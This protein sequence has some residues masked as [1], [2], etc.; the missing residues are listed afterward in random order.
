MEVS[1]GPLIQVGSSLPLCFY[2]FHQFHD[3]SW[4]ISSPLF[5]LQP[6]RSRGRELGWYPL[7]ELWQWLLFSCSVVSDSA[8]PRT[9]ACQTS[10]SFPISWNLLRLMSVDLVVQSNYL[11]LCLPLLLLPSIF[12]IIRVLSN[13]LALCIRRLKHWSFGFS[14][15]P[16][17]EHSR[18]ISFRIDWFD[19]LAVQGTLKSLFQHRDLKASI[20]WCSVFF[21]VQPSHLYMTTRKI[22]GWYLS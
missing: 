12:P 10:L 14:I 13:E 7:S 2:S 17:S 4:P 20:L 22:N 3:L 5:Y 9:A 19:L 21:T 16:S 6:F 8:T 15:S 11:I 18:L 1:N